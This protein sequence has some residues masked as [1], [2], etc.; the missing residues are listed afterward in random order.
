MTQLDEV[1]YAQ[2][3]DDV[4]VELC[5]IGMPRND[6]KDAIENND[7]I[8]ENL[9]VVAVIYNVCGFKKRIKLMKE[10]L[11][12]MEF[13]NHVI[14]YVV[15]LAYKNQKHTVT[16]SKNPRHLQ[17][18]VEDALWHKENMI[19]VGVQKLL[20][21]S[22][23]AFAWID[24]D[25]EFENNDWALDTLKILN[26]A[27][28]IVQLFSHAVDMDAH[29]YTMNVYNSFSYQYT[30]GLPYT[31]KFPN[32]WHPGYAW[33]CTRKAYEKMGGLFQWGILGASDYIMS[34]CLAYKGLESIGTRYSEEFKNKVR[35]YEQ[36]VKRLRL[37]YT[38]GVIRHHFHGL[39]VNRRYIERNEILLK[40]NYNPD[41]HVTVNHDGVLIPT[42]QCPRPFLEEILEYFRQRNEDDE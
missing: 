17:L 37:G 32:Y 13:E 18:R 41:K 42:A 15:E 5:K 8:E 24:A 6:I 11:R 7:P 35:A 10:F 22:W 40:Y 2:K 19:N 20:P 23:K 14:V 34:F 3:G 31:H 16:S 25:I 33:A 36:L 21:S 9:H 28:D 39:K 30:R 26:G 1:P 38:P 12:R 27:K 4:R 29:E